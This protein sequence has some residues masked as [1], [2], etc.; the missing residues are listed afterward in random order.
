MPTR[1]MARTILPGLRLID[2]DVTTLQRLTIEAFDRCIGFGIAIHFDKRKTFGLTRMHVFD[3]IDIANFAEAR[4]SRAEIVFGHA[5]GQVTDVNVHNDSPFS[6]NS[7]LQSLPFPNNQ[8]TIILKS[9]IRFGTVILHTGHNPVC[10]LTMFYVQRPDS[11]RNER[12][13]QT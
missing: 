9:P 5:I 4:E 3:D 13:G 6:K 12:G 11:S 2:F 7:V 8:H 10:S 1:A